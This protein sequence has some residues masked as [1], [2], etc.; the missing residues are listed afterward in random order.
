MHHARLASSPRL[1]RTLKALQQANGEISTLDL[2][3][4]VKIANVSATISELR[5]NGAVIVCRQLFQDD[6]RSFFYTL[7]KSPKDY[8]ASRKID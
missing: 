5:A 7:T 8:H 6:Q 3:Q 1:R 2:L 4:K